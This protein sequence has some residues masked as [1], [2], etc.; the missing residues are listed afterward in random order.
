MEKG[1]SFKIK[2]VLGSPEYKFLNRIENI[3][4]LSSIVGSTPV[5]PMD[6]SSTLGVL[7][8]VLRQGL[9]V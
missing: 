8:F 3:Q 7:C 4:S 1:S 9:T 6:V 2:Y 5:K